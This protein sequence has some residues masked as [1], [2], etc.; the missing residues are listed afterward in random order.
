MTTFS[1]TLAGKLFNGRAPVAEDVSLIWMGATVK[2]IGNAITL[3]YPTNQLRVSPRVGSAHRF[4]TLPDGG[5]LQ[6]PDAALLDRL[7]QEGKTEG[8]V[9][10]LEQRWLV[11]L[12]S[13]AL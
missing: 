1:N 5:Q 9:A 8:S 6:C 2:I 10:W 13:V 4:I 7:P 12:V 11:A 3:D